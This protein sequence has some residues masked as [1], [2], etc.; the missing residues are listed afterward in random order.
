MARYKENIELARKKANIIHAK[1]I[2]YSPPNCFPYRNEVFTSAKQCV[3]CSVTKC[4]L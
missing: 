2:S 4:L 3:T 1:Y